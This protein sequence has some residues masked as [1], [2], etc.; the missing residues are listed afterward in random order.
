VRDELL[1]ELHIAHE[2]GMRF[3]RYWTAY[4]QRYGGWNERYKTFSL[5]VLQL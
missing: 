5:L 1:A 3:A 4:A 2:I